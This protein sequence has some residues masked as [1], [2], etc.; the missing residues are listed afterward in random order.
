MRIACLSHLASREA[1]T[2]AERSLGLLATGLGRRGHETALAVP[3]AWWQEEALLQESGVMLVRAGCRCLWLTSADRQPVVKQLLRGIRF[4][5]PDPDVRRLRRWLVRFNPDVVHVNCLP[6]VRAAELAFRLGLPVVWHLREIL[7]PGARRRWFANRLRRDSTKVVAV[8]EAVARWLREENL[9]DRVVVVHNGVTAPTR[10]PKKTDARRILGLPETGCVVVW[11][12]QIRSHKG[13]GAFVRSVGRA[14]NRVPELHAVLAGH[15]PQVEVDALRG[16]IAASAHRSRF[17]LLPPVD[18]V[19]PLL[20]AADMAA[21]TTLAPDPLPRTVLEAM[22]SGLPVVAFAVG[23]V[24]EMVLEGETGLLGAVG[25]EEGL[26][27][28]IEA[29]ALDSDRRRRLG[30]R[31][32]E[33]ALSEFSLERH[34]DRMETVLRHAVGS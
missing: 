27:E 26:A 32:R 11:L 23:G 7:P 29:L 13:A 34:V 24:P 5:A 3:G 1:P 17:L 6:Y 4:V 28:S 15:G 22:A 30:A 20:A 8:S 18:D 12:G 25:D 14:M 33:R 2:G 19:Q 31:G 9:G 16:E 10:T 21:I